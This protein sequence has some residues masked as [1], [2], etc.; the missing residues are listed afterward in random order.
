MYVLLLG[1]LLKIFLAKQLRT[2][3]REKKIKFQ[4]INVQPRMGARQET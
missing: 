4:E 3:E 1:E 2:L